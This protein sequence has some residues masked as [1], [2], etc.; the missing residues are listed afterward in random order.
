MV[1]KGRVIDLMGPLDRCKDKTM[2]T[3]EPYDYPGE[4]TP[5]LV[6]PWFYRGPAGDLKPG[7]EVIYVLFADQTGMILSRMDGNW[8]G[9]LSGDL[10]LLIEADN[11]KSSLKCKNIDTYEGVFEMH[12]DQTVGHIKIEKGDV[13]LD[14]GSVLVPK[15]DVKTTVSLS[16][17]VHQGVR[18]GTESTSK[19]S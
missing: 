9:R 6:I 10:E 11:S 7:D 3:V 15:G 12:N 2:A 16:E 14:D 8:T 1:K 4:V 13:I 19:P 17:H 5:K 18:A